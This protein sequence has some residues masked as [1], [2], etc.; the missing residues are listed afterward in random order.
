MKNICAWSNRPVELVAPGAL[1][2]T[3]ALLDALLH[4]RGC[5]VSQTTFFDV[6]G[7][8]KAEMT[9]KSKRF[10]KV[11]HLLHNNRIE[12]RGIRSLRPSHYE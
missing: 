5:S 8:V 11:I 3:F 12:A 4:P 1:S 6:V 2:H 7:F 9:Q 10:G